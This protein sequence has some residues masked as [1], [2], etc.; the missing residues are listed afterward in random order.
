VAE[1]ID[2]RKTPGYIKIPEEKAVVIQSVA[3][4]PDSLEG[5]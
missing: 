2:D 5:M 1:F 4:S 3:V